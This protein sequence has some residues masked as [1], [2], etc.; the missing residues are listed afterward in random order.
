V[1]IKV[2]VLDAPTEGIDIGSRLEI[3]ELLRELTAEGMAVVIFS[4]DFEEVRL[5]A[6]RAIVLRRGKL[7]GELGAD[8]ITEERLYALQY[9]TAATGARAA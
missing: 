1:G 3:Y 2:L 4:S 7:V 8:E 9:G 5:V 6:D